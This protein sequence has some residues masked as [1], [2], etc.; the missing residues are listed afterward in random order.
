MQKD[1]LTAIDESSQLR[2][3]MNQLEAALNQIL[4]L[5]IS[6]PETRD[7]TALRLPSRG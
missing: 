2:V 3:I 7:C 6:L 1:Q 5:C 4:R